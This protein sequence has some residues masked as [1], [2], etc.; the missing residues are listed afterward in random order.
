[1][2]VSAL[3]LALLGTALLTA[4]SPEPVR[5]LL[6]LVA[7]DAAGGQGGRGIYIF[8]LDGG[9]K[10]VRKIDLPLKGARG[11]CAS[12]AAGRLWISHGDTSVLCLDL[13]TDKVLWEKTYPR[14]DGCDR[15]CCT[16]DGRKVYVPSGPWSG[17]PEWKILDGASG[18]ERG[19]FRPHRSGGGHNAAVSLDGSRLYCASKANNFLAVVD[20]ATDQVVVEVGPVGGG[21]HPFTVNAAGTRCYLNTGRAGVGF[22]VGDLRTGRILHRAKVPGLEGQKRLCHGIGL[23]PDEKEIWLNDQGQVHIFDITGDA[24]RF[25]ETVKLTGRA[26]GWT[27]FSLDGRF[28]YPDSGE[29]FDTRTHRVVAH[30]TDGRGKRVSSSK[31]IEVHFRAGDVVRVGD[32]FGLGRKIAAGQGT[33]G[34]GNPGQGVGGRPRPVKVF[35]LAGQSNMEGKAKLSLL[36]YQARQPATRA[37]FAHLRKDGK[38]VEREDVWIKYREHQGR[39]TAGYGSPRCVGPELGFGWVVGD[40]FPEQ[41]L[42]LK[43][44]WGGRS[45][46]RDFR[47]PSAGLPTERALEGLLAQQRKRDPKATLE[48]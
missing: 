21:I 31:M 28:A 20:T 46:Y 47:P 4:A 11:V 34:A 12:A 2:P 35:V 10:L 1:L 30:L 38:W 22:E 15:L 41:V 29:V 7:P 39:L 32:Q 40:H 18:R 3:L 44:A 5:R 8:D 16:P 6:Y 45:L 48:A 33:R 42:L 23:S 17:S 26:H 27:T 9:H 43:T 25:V 36:D 24:P 13:K 14:K 19:R 37:L